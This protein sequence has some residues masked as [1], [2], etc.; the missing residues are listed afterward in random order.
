M[1]RSI[2]SVV[3]LINLQS[4]SLCLLGC[5]AVYV[6]ARLHLSFALDISVV[7]FGVTFSVS[8]FG[9]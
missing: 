5:A 7:V 2:R 3:Y 1:S 8:G 6:C 4:V 9:D